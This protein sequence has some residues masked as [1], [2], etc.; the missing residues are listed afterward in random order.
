ML[1]ASAFLPHRGTELDCQAVPP[2]SQGSLPARAG[3]PLTGRAL[4]PLDDSQDFTNSSHRSIPP[5]QHCLVALNLL[6]THS[7]RVFRVPDAAR[8]GGSLAP[9]VLNGGWCALVPRNSRRISVGRSALGFATSVASPKRRVQ[10]TGSD[11]RT[12]EFT[13]RLGGRINFSAAR[14]DP[15]PGR[16]GLLVDGR[17]KR[18]RSNLRR[19]AGRPEC[20]LS[21]AERKRE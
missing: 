12:G 17:H 14:I 20:D 7:S 13:E 21:I 8:L 6:S 2:P 16:E 10:V 3:S 1:E 9:A 5:D 18:P 4:H 19:H 15:C 11:L